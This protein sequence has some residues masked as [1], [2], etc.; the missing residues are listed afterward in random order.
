[1]KLSV[2]TVVY[3]NRD[4]VADAIDSVLGQDYPEVEYVV[5]DG[6]SA[7][8]TLDIIRGYGERIDRV[9]SESDRGLYDAMN[10]GVGL[11]TGDVIGIL[12][13]DDVYASTTV[14]SSVADAMLREQAECAYGDLV[15]VAHDDLDRVVRYWRSGDYDRRKWRWG[16]MPPHPTFFARRELYEVCGLYDLRLRSSADYEFMLRALYRHQ[17]RPVYVPDTLVKMR[18][19]GQSN[20]SLK[21][22]VRAHLEDRRAWE[23]NHYSSDLLRMLF[24]PLRKVSQFFVRDRLL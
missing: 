24:K 18:T 15:Y 10:K 7:D 19:G 23:M 14:L 20:A 2:I 3:N 12:N 17:A 8:G 16:W 13:S 1:M 9:I 11:A 21:N 4:T 6:G 22:R 5:V